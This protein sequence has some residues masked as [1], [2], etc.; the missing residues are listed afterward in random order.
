ME[1]PEQ[2]H[3]RLLR[4][5]LV[6]SV[7]SIIVASFVLGMVFRQNSIENLVSLGEDKN[8]NVAR[9]IS[10]H[11][12]PIYREQLF[13]AETL[14]PSQ[15]HEQAFMQKLQL[16]IDGH[17]QSTSIIK[18]KI[19]NLKGKTLFSTAADQIGKIKTDSKPLSQA[20]EG[21]TVT[22]LA[23][24]D[25]FYA[26]DEL[27]TEL[28]VLSTYLPIK[29]N[30]KVD[31][32]IEVYADVTALYESVTQ[33]RNAVI[34]GVMF[35]L[36][37]LYAVIFI[38]VYKA[39]KTIKQ[40]FREKQDDE[41][42]IRHI[43]YHDS[44]TGLPNRE[45]YRFTVQGAI[46]QAKRNESLLG[47]LFIDLDRFKQINDSLGHTIGDA[48]LVEVALRLKKC[49][50]ASD[51]VAR[52]GGDEFTILLESI[53]HVDEIVHVC[54][55]INASI[56]QSYN[57]EGNEMFTSASIGVTVYPFD[58]LELENLLKDAD[59]AMYE[60]K[61]AG[62]NNYVFFSSGM[63]RSNM[64]QLS[65]E[66][67]L[68]KALDENE[69]LLQFQPIVDLRKGKMVGVEALLRWSSQEYGIVSPMKF[70][71]LLEETGVMEIVGE[72]VLNTACQ[73]VK[74]WHEEGYEPITIAVNISMVQ[75]RQMNFV[76]TVE[77]ALNKS[78]LD[79]KYLKLE[80]TES[81]LMDQSDASVEKLLAVR[82]LGVMIEADDFG[83][84][85]SSL[86]YLKKL[87]VDILK[88]DRSF[89]TDVHKSSDSA[90]IVTAIM[91]MAYSLK[92]DI[93]AEGVEEIE[94]LK[95]LSALN[96][97]YIQGYLFSKPLAED[98]LKKVMSDP[99]HFC[100]ILQEANTQDMAVGE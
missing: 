51:I 37:L 73:K 82:A 13:L 83:T 16:D 89:I 1:K 75:F 8:V 3:F 50:R 94:E 17:I 40:Q 90:A 2:H 15:M 54:K 41:K 76:K 25:K 84:G 32:I 4:Y 36:L 65:L 62:R 47:I 48:L 46:E 91:A 27:L 97:H 67:D 86:S 21:Q 60:A 87:P 85:Y 7:S 34:G 68:R 33:E 63:K 61:N 39:D 24:R 29:I 57:I 22:R 38:F 70:I 30:N 26:R 56:S 93:I 99:D 92:L 23:F 98:D 20:I 80:L 6:V 43:A 11:I 77:I 5:F 42:M 18:V 71:P 81:M 45:L 72:W 88:I 9:V 55:R 59:T 79:P 52:Q 28:N 49:V 95:F 19:Y 66:I 96:C 53:K 14:T 74:Q 44:L 64:E 69:Y 78:Q 12:W 31:G 35:V 10:N 100:K 58:D